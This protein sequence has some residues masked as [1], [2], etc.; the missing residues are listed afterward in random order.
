MAE[1]PVFSSFS[2]SGTVF[3]GNPIVPVPTFNIS[4]A[5]G[6]PPGGSSEIVNALIQNLVPQLFGLKGSQFGQFMPQMNLYDQLKHRSAYEMQEEAAGHGAMIDKQ[7][8][9]NV[10]KT[11][12]NLAGTP[13]GDRERESANTLAGDMATLMPMLVKSA[14]EIADR[15]H[16]SRG[17]AAVMAMRMA[18]GSRYMTDPETGMLGMS[19][20]SV[21][22]MH[23][24]VHEDLFGEKSD[25]L[26]MRGITA[27][28]AGGMFDEMGRRGII[29][30]G[31]RTLS[32]IMGNSTKT[33]EEFLN[34]PGFS[35]KVQQ[36]ESS[37]ISEKIRGMAGAISAVKDIF[38]ENGRQDA[39]M[40][41]L[42]NALQ[43][44]TQNNIANMKPAE[45][46]RM[47]RSASTV[48]KM[49]GMTLE[50]MMANLAGA[51]QVTDK[52][53]LG[54]SF[55][56]RIASNSALYAQ[57]H[58]SV[59]GGLEGFGVMG[60]EEILGIRR[61]MTA[62]GAASPV[63][64]AMAT[65][66]RGVQSGDISSDNQEV[67]DY[68]K[69]LKA[70]NAKVKSISEIRAMAE[71]A[72]MKASTF[73]TVMSQQDTNQAIID[74]NKL[75]LNVHA[76]QREDVRQL[77]EHQLIADIAGTTDVD[78]KTSDSA[79]KYI[80]QRL[81]RMTKDELQ[82]FSAG[83]FTFLQ[84]GVD[85]N[86]A[87]GTFKK[88][89]SNLS[90]AAGNI[91]T[92]AKQ[93]GYVN[94]TNFYALNNEQVAEQDQR[95]RE[96]E[97]AE[98]T[99][100]THMSVLNRSSPLQRLSDL[101]INGSAAHREVGDVVK[102]LFG[103]VD[104]TKLSKLDQEAQDMLNSSNSLRERN[105]SKDAQVISLGQDASEIAKISQSYALTPDMLNTV[106][107]N[108]ADPEAIK[109]TLA[110]SANAIKSSIA[111]R[112]PQIAKRLGI[113]TEESSLQNN[114]LRTVRNAAEARYANAG[115][116]AFSLSSAITT[117][118]ETLKK[119]TNEKIETVSSDLRIAGTA[120][121]DINNKPYEEL[122]SMYYD[123]DQVRQAN[124]ADLFE[125]RK[126]FDK[127]GVS[128]DL[129][130]TM[131][132]EDIDVDTADGKL[133]LIDN[134]HADADDRKRLEKPIK[135]LSENK[136]KLLNATATDKEKIIKTIEENQRLIRADAQIHG[137]SA[138]SI[139]G[140]AATSKLSP[141]QQ[142][143]AR[144]AIA[145]ENITKNDF[146]K[147]LITAAEDAKKEGITLNSY[148]NNSSESAAIAKAASSIIVDATASTERIIK[149][150]HTLITPE[151]DA[152]NRLSRNQLDRKLLQPAKAL[153]DVLKTFDSNASNF[154]PAE[155][156][157]IETSEPATKTKLATDLQAIT[158][159]I[160]DKDGKT[161]QTKKAS[162]ASYFKNPKSN[163][164]LSLEEISKLDGV[165]PELRS[166]I[167][168][169][170][171][172]KI[173]ELLDKQ[174]KIASDT[175]KQSEY[176]YVRLDSNTK[177]NGSLDLSTGDLQLIPV[178]A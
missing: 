177:L 9:E 135:E 148:L 144:K 50:G 62:A 149:S 160:E 88:I 114:V 34:D 73:N 138:E 29:G 94:S 17:S 112:V 33:K 168:G 87:P 176:A 10:F 154:T 121:D 43:K 100:Q 23:A 151:E 53:G 41:E 56:P 123:D 57:A 159:I 161:D 97:S 116:L 131:L 35:Q 132:D 84:A 130:Y 11:I 146:K 66:F 74:K 78:T 19:K 14:P 173:T 170:N 25:I 68:M 105:I 71:R 79:S 125:K 63:A 30:S 157:K 145:D 110:M 124:V 126:K 16:G 18:A 44:M 137:Y 106:L 113:S 118:P 61:Q 147:S 133:S 142:K 82:S 119:F 37:K 1:N 153:E 174:N 89:K 92:L 167:I 150:P 69:D 15:M 70:G 38:G 26:Q 75:E 21:K 101:F 111:Q 117:D 77:T 22:A 13:Y 128:D 109:H 67:S 152:K 31:N 129:F 86:T 76:H 55:A 99:L 96:L 134:I 59:L 102:E 108:G 8:Y 72:G 169:G 32:E 81:M 162:V 5:L 93:I 143:E 3:G 28:Q 58:G 60:K 104:D 158:S 83:D 156:R 172:A 178:N 40:S 64:N 36:F 120:L 27:G 95:N 2:G 47:V 164:N 4:Q 91:N 20:R 24:N 141:E 175:K 49:T 7:V 80:S 140:P 52:F 85:A 48:A 122:S 139:L 136:E 163:T 51:G 90:I 155:N 39:P 46:E 98:T 42:F 166:A 12:A 107:S 103:M 171:P 115:S 6:M 54:R 45:A 165:S 65:L 127:S